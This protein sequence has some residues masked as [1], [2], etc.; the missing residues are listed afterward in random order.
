[1]KKKKGQ[2]EYEK[3]L[4]GLLQKALSMK[5]HKNK[6]QKRKNKEIAEAAPKVEVDQP[7]LSLNASDVTG[8][9]P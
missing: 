1:M 9:T 7:E 6:R 8:T 3:H 4:W 5:K 2:E